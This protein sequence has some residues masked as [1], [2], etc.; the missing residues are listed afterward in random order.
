MQL[1]MHLHEMQAELE[2]LMW[3]RKELDERLQTAI[4][5]RRMMEVM[6][7]EFEEEYDQ[8]IVQIELMEGE[9]QD[10]KD[11]NHQLKEVQFKAC[12]SIR[13]Q[14]DTGDGQK[15]GDADK[16]GIPSGISSRRSGD[17]GSDI[18]LEEFLIHKDSWEDEIKSEMPDFIKTGSKVSRPIHTITPGMI[19]RSVDM[20]EV[21][22]RRREVAL[23]QSLFSAI[24]FLLVGMIIWEADDPCMPLVVG[25]F[26]VVC[27]SLKSVVLFFSTIKNESASDAVALLSFNWFILGTLTYP[28]LP[29]A[30]HIFSPLALCSLEQTVR[31][32]GFSS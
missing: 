11:E 7:A 25:L 16:D 32:L 5:E 6:L 8:A 27:M 17:N 2:Y 29:K 22:V 15:T 26:T 30:A 18:T 14:D 10:L 20:H 1:E 9:L 19:S 23:S 13:S 3:D 28:T 31:W 12:S 4:K 24:L 21:L